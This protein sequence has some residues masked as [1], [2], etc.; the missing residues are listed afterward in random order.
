MGFIASQPLQLALL[1]Q[2][3]R[4]PLTSFSTMLLATR[5]LFNAQ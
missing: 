1:L 4:T 5:T 3:Q 2:Q